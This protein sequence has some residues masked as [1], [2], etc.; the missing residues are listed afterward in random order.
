ML[1][2]NSKKIQD[3]AK[4]KKSDTHL[5]PEDHEKIVEM[6]KKPAKIHK[7]S[8]SQRTP[9]FYFK[10]TDTGTLSESP[11]S[12]RERR[13]KRAKKKLLR[14][15]KRAEEFA[16]RLSRELIKQQNCDLPPIAS[17]SQSNV[18]TIPKE[19][20]PETQGKLEKSAPVSPITKPSITV[21]EK[22]SSTQNSEGKSPSKT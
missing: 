20:T 12:E 15:M 1:V 19:G 8:E 10:E 9:R 6:L 3:D 13:E 18:S 11:P 21:Q 17:K 2:D 16:T 14:R 7:N 5:L 22:E 4:S